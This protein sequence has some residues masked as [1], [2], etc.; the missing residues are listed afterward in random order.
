[1]TEK[2]FTAPRTAGLHY[3]VT[4]IARLDELKFIVD[5]SIKR[6]V[7]SFRVVLRIVQ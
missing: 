6:A 2:Y 7:A 3:S 4:V 5:R 1:M